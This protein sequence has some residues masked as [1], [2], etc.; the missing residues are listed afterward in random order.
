MVN[1]AGQRGNGA[2]TA[3]EKEKGYY[4]PPAAVE[5]PKGSGVICWR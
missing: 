5:L 2:I 1:S 3:E 4:S